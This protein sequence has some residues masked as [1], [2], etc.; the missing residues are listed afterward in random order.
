MCGCK[1]C[2]GTLKA[3]CCHKQRHFKVYTDR[4]REYRT[5]ECS[6]PPELSRFLVSEHFPSPLSNVDSILYEHS[7][8]A[9]PGLVCRF[10]VTIAVYLFKSTANVGLI[11]YLFMSAVIFLC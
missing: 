8:V 1:A 11:T 3:N 6:I 5:K 4:H 7:D 9:L 2:Q 10:I